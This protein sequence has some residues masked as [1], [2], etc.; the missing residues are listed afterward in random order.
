M[1]YDIYAESIAQV[2]NVPSETLPSCFY[3]NAGLWNTNDQ[4]EYLWSNFKIRMVIH[5][6]TDGSVVR[7]NIGGQVCILAGNLGDQ[8]H[9]LVAKTTPLV[10]M[11]EPIWQQG[12]PLGS[13]WAWPFQLKQVMYFIHDSGSQKKDITVSSDPVPSGEGLGCVRPTG[14]DTEPSN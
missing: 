12:V 11:Y 8:F 6:L 9:C 7:S 3:T 10:Q 14:S 2:L 4:E 1:R 5:A 13:V